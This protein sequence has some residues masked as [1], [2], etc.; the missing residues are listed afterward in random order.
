MK[1]TVINLV[2]VNKSFMDHNRPHAVLQ[3]L[4]FDVHEGE[5]VTLLGESG[6]GKSTILNLV[7]GFMHP[8]SGDVY[9]NGSKVTKPERTCLTLFQHHNLLP[10]RTVLDNVLLGFESIDAQ[11]N[12]RATEA[13][14]LVGLKDFANHFPKELSGGMQQRVAIA[15]AFTMNPSVILMDEPFAA[16][17]TFNRYHLQDELLKLQAEN[18]LTTLLVTHD[19]DEAIYLSDRI[20]IMSANPGTIYEE[21]RID[22]SKPRSRTQDDFYYYRNKIL[23]TFELSRKQTTP[24]YFI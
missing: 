4:S 15:R 10:W 12:E 21:I 20:L 24:E 13:L 18:S 8:D 19:I 23:H 6:C 16:L 22:L 1:Q 17:D 11:I 2:H 3:D 5:F 9:V 14:A 7:G